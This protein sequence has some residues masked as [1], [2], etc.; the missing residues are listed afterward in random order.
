GSGDGTLALQSGGLL[1]NFA[2]DGRLARVT[3]VFD[4]LRPSAPLYSYSGSAVDGDPVRLSAITDPVSGR[5]V[6]LDYGG[7]TARPCAAPTKMLCRIRFWDGAETN[8]V[9]DAGRLA[10]VL[11]PSGTS[12]NGSTLPTRYDFG[13]N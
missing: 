8:L 4:A 11:N 6:E 3:S 9:Y 13:Y 12:Y 7:N 1:Y 10:A 5:K 2:V